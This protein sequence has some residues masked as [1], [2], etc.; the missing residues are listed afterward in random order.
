MKK[1][2]L[3]ALVMETSAQ[4]SFVIIG[5]GLSLC[6]GIFTWWWMGVV[7]CINQNFTAPSC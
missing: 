1:R 5:Y 3:G 7:L 4:N 6:V 2:G